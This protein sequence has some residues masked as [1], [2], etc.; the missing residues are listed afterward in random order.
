MKLQHL[1]PSCVVI[2]LFSSGIMFFFGFCCQPGCIHGDAFA[3][4]AIHIVDIAG[5]GDFLHLQDAINAASDFDTI[6]VKK[7]IYREHV[8]VN[9]PLIIKG[10]DKEKTVIDGGFEKTVITITAD[11]VNL[12]HVTIRNSGRGTNAG[13]KI[14]GSSHVTISSCIVYSNYYGIW[15]YQSTVNTIF[16][17]YVYG[18][19]YG[20]MLHYVSQ[21]NRIIS[22]Q[23]EDNAH[24]GIY[25][26]CSSTQNLISECTIKNNTDYGI[27]IHVWDTTVYLNNFIDNGV[28][29]QS[30]YST[31]WDNGE[32][33]NY[34]SD[35]DEEHE[36]AHDENDDGI[37]DEGYVIPDD[38]L[39]HYPLIH[40][41]TGG[42]TGR[43][44]PGLTFTVLVCALIPYLFI[45][46][47]P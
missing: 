11:E 43:S 2:P 24:T 37:V 25:L 10:E 46:K 36:G 4:G 8:I 44:L 18:N 14:E 33:G 15:A 47:R 29:A 34:W 42:D 27:D 21:D 45:K 41:V 31:V 23:V 19:Y 32:R 9:K 22:C 16:D 6:I 38:N 7:G 3:P 12:N 17:C 1:L 13:I 30:V 20:I 40:R 26:C 28:N 39:D 5:E 35:F